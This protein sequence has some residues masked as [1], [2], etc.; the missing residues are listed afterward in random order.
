MADTTT[1]K[2]E[3]IL[4]KKNAGSVDLSRVDKSTDTHLMPEF[5]G[6]KVHDCTVTC[7][8]EPTITY[9]DSHNGNRVWT[10]QRIE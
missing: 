9:A 5:P 1:K 2:P 8:C 10:H 3:I 4:R 6:E 7:W